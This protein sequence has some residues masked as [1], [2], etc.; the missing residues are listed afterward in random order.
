ASIATLLLAAGASAAVLA[1]AVTQADPLVVPLT[2]AR[3]L[4]AGGDWHA[5][6]APKRNGRWQLVTQ[7]PDGTVAAAEGIR[8]F[9]A[10]PDH[11]I[12]ATSFA[13]AEKRIVA[14]YS[15]CKGSS[16][17]TG[18]DVYQYDL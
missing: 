13:V 6:A 18:C 4:A 10:A 9:G 16:A 5:W 3:N 17:T 15:R 8:D 14:V 1:P 2:G 12:G 7:A 11:S